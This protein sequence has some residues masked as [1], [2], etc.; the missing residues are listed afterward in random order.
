MDIVVFH[1]P[2]RPYSPI[3]ALNRAAAAMGSPS[4]AA[5]TAGADYNGHRV[6][7]SYNEHCHYWIAEY[8]WAGRVVLRRGNL[9]DCVVAALVE[10]DRGA[11]GSEVVVKVQS[12]DAAAAAYC[13]SHPR[14]VPGTDA[15]PWWTW[16]HD[17][18]RWCARDAANARI[19]V[20]LFDWDLL[21]DSED[22]FAYECAVRAKHGRIYQ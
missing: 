16:R 12:S 11:L 6:T 2:T 10:F 17:V 3:D 21:Q 14:L 20:M 8:V 15:R 1:I 13:A 9:E 7:V 18:A 4:Y 22:Q 5:R 19:P